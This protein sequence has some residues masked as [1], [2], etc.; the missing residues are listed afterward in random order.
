LPVY[1]YCGW[2]SKTL[3]EWLLSLNSMTIAH[4]HK[5]AQLITIGMSSTA[6]ACHVSL[7]SDII[8]L[9]AMWP[10]VRQFH[11]SNLSSH[12]SSNLMKTDG[13]LLFNLYTAALATVT[14]SESVN[15][16][17]FFVL[18]FLLF[19]L[20][21]IYFFVSFSRVTLEMSYICHILFTFILFRI[22]II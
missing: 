15:H 9:L 6:V 14:E 4:G 22:C 11:W 20:W 10:K 21:S 1:E 13:N 18:F 8:T 5:T 7:V 2:A 12:S 3:S 19:F 17:Y 16:H